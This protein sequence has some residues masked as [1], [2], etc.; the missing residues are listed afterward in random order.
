[1]I[2]PQMLPSNN[3]NITGLSSMSIE[4]IEMILYW[5]HHL[6][7]TRHTDQYQETESSLNEND[8]PRLRKFRETN[9]SLP[10]CDLRSL[11]SVNRS[12]HKMLSPYLFQC[13]DFEG[14]A[15]NRLKLTFEDIIDRHSDQFREIRARFSYSH[16]PDGNSKSRSE[17][18][19]KILKSCAHLTD[20]DID[21]DPERLV[22]ATRPNIFDSGALQDSSVSNRIPNLFFRPICQLTSLTH[23]SLSSPH[24]RPPYTEHFLRLSWLSLG[25]YPLE[26]RQDLEDLINERLWPNLKKLEI[27]SHTS[28]FRR[29][30]EGLNALCQRFSIETIFNVDFYSHEDEV[31]DGAGA[32]HSIGIDELQGYMHGSHGEDWIFYG[33]WP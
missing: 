6:P 23:L 15:A 29:A 13:F 21:L 12:L 14:F 1:M 11:A 28:S 9:D 17:L 26:P 30:V 22:P 31:Y 2:L 24:P 5:V 20:I 4:V 7:S 18:L 8:Y 19:L 3:H 10:L 32:D 25:N 16:E 27:N 33:G